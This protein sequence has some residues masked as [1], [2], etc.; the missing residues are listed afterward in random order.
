MPVTKKTKRVVIK[1]DVCNLENQRD[2]YQKF[3]QFVVNELIVL[4]KG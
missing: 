3:F 4:M 2:G 1:N